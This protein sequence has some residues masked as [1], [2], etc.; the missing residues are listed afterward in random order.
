MNVKYLHTF[1]VAILLETAAAV[2]NVK[3]SRCEYFSASYNAKQKRSCSGSN[4]TH[5]SAT[6]P[7][8]ISIGYNKETM[9]GG[10]CAANYFVEKGSEDRGLHLRGDE[11]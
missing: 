9:P 5:S 7:I 11:R 3:P 2:T 10:S 1:T 4:H 6:P 8:S